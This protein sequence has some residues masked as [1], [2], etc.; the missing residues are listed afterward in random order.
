LANRVPDSWKCLPYNTAN[1]IAPNLIA[2]GQAPLKLRLYGAIEIR[3][4]Y[5]YYYYYYKQNKRTQGYK[6]KPQKLSLW[7]QGSQEF[8]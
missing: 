8:N 3:F 2:V 6:I 5:Y 4:Y 7:A 1:A